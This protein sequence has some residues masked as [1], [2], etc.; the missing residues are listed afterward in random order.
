MYVKMQLVSL[1]F[2]LSTLALGT[3]KVCFK[4]SAILFQNL[5]L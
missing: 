2:F 1:N 3:K 5:S 4:F